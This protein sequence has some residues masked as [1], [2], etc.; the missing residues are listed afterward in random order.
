[1]F[2]DRRTRRLNATSLLRGKAPGVKSFSTGRPCR[3]VMAFPWLKV[4]V[5][6]EVVGIAMFAV[7]LVVEVRMGAQVGFVLITSGG[8]VITVGT[9]ML[10]KVR[11]LFRRR[12]SD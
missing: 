1:M 7:G 11:N 8:A 10:V 5:I 4:S 6:L 12:A 2:D 3:R 9:F